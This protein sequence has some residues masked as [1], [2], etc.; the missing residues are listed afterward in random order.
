MERG[1]GRVSRNLLWNFAFNICRQK[2]GN[3]LTMCEKKQ[4]HREETYISSLPL[5]ASN[6]LSK[7]CCELLGSLRRKQNK[8]KDMCIYAINT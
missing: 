7:C 1:E 3:E 8:T 2:E 5:S 4:D 6:Q